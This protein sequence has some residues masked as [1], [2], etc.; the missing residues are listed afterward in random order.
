[1]KPITEEQ[2]KAALPP[3]VK[4]LVNSQIVDSINAVLQDEETRE[5]FRENLLSYGN[6]MKEG[7]FKMTSYI[8]AVKYVSFKLLGKTNKDAYINTFPDKYQRFLLAGVEEKVIAS[9]TSTY[10]KSKLVN[11]IYEQTL[12]PTHVLNA[13]MFQDALNVQASLMLNARS[14]KVRSDAAN[15]LLIHLKRPETTKLELDIGL[16]QDKTIEVLRAT[17]QKL[18]ETQKKLIASR[19]CDAKEI[20]E[21]TLVSAEDIIDV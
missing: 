1:M 11:L 20:A 7:R 8:S 6:V 14:E 12:I 10:N 17:T 19:S 15:S 21:A 18:V 3:T 5:V 13:H 9:Y 16:K 2:F 4:R